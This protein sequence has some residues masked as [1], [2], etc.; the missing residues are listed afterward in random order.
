MA[1]RIGIGFVGAGNISRARHVPGFQAIDGVELVGVSNRTP[2]S[3][4]RAA[5]EFGFPKTYPTWRDLLDDDAIDAVVVGTWPYLHAPVTIAALE[6]GRHVLTQ[7][8]MA[9]NAEQAEAMLAASLERP[10]LVA[11]V[12]PAPTTL[13]A[14]ATVQ[15]VLREGDL[16]ELR[17]MRV[18]F[19]GSASGGAP[20]P[21]RR[22]RRFSG[23]NVMALGIVYECLMRWL[24]HARFVDARLENF[25][26][27]GVVD[28]KRELYDVPDYVAILAE[29][30]GP[31]HSTIE[32][33]SYAVAG[34]ANGALLFG[35]EG[36]LKVD[37]DAR[38]LAL[39]RPSAPSDWTPVERRKDE[40]QPDWR[41]E[42]E[43]IGAIRGT[44]E[45][46]L[47]DFATAARYMAFT[48]AVHESSRT[49]VR[50]AL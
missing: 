49:G 23:N 11:M 31:V 10:D 43:F 4:K 22:Q 9:M 8:R 28:G 26:P 38:R 2:A 35:S 37:F 42:A 12:V 41:V 5:K 16:G 21:W 25:T 24:G 18:T 3:T 40:Q 17:S 1:K 46:R 33:S 15:R 30:P 14:D 39:A 27:A 45:V 20:D 7:A 47:T 44:E 32:V 36:T 13:W 6:S 29:F 19:G 48:D 34:N 50:I